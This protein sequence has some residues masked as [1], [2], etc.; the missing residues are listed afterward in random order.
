MRSARCECAPPESDGPLGHTTG[1]FTGKMDTVRLGSDSKDCF[2][3]LAEADA[4]RGIEIRR[5]LQIMDRKPRRTEYMI[6]IL[7]FRGKL[8]FSPDT[9]SFRHYHSCFLGT[10]FQSDSGLSPSPQETKHQEHE[11][12][13]V[14][15]WAH[16]FF[17]SPSLVF[18][19]HVSRDHPKDSRECTVQAELE[20]HA[21][22]VSNWD[23]NNHRQEAT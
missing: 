9:D 18:I 17:A 8:H 1:V 15:S 23:G 11:Y 7:I 14:Q 12:C 22:V 19:I 5:T 6:I 16:H 4:R 20:D 21:C 10:K 3:R 13:I 2:C